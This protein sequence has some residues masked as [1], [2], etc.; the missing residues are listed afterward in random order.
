[1]IVIPL[2]VKAVK[3]IDRELLLLFGA[4]QV[5]GIRVYAKTRG[6]QHFERVRSRFA[7]DVLRK[8]DDRFRKCHNFE[9]RREK[10][11]CRK[12]NKLMAR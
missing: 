12:E 11:V 10:Q 8:L 6:A 7:T 2:A 9:G 5:V 4:G 3:V 1:M